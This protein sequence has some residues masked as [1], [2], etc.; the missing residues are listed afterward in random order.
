[1]SLSR[2]AIFFALFIGSATP[3][4]AAKAMSDR[5][6]L[7]AEAEHVCYDDAQKLCPDAM[8]DEVKVEACMKAKRAQLSSGCSKVFDKGA[9]L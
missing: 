2:A 5:E 7:R 4:L 8:P 3:L 9:K 6:M 1:M